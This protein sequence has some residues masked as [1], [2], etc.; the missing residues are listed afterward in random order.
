MQ[1]G[2]LFPLE[3]ILLFTVRF[4]ERSV[5]GLAVVLIEMIKSKCLSRDCTG[6]GCW[7]VQAFVRARTIS[8]ALPTHCLTYPDCL[9]KL[10]PFHN[11]YKFGK[12]RSYSEV[13][14]VDRVLFV[15]SQSGY[16]LLVNVYSFSEP[17][18]DVFTLDF[19][20]LHKGRNPGGDISPAKVTKVSECSSCKWLG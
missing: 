5:F 10:Y 13:S 19:P 8:S 2:E 3:L 20:L 17:F 16:I 6:G 9:P 4:P 1:K 18:M 11:W 15:S 7:C 14:I 12:S